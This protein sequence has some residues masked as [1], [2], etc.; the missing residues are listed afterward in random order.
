MIPCAQSFHCLF[1]FGYEDRGAKTTGVLVVPPIDPGMGLYM[2]CNAAQLSDQ[3]TLYTHGNDQFT[4]AIT[5]LATAAKAE[6]KVD[7]RPI[8]RF[9]DNGSSLTIEFVDGSSKEETF[10]VHNPKT[11]V[12]GAFVEQL[13]LELSP[14]GDIKAS[15]PFYQTSVRGVFS[16]GDAVNPY[17]AANAAISSGCN[18][19]VAA[20]AQLQA[21]KYGI[22]AML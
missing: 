14:T 9:V 16:A 1:C 3:V 17:K 4:N 15:G 8:K 7:S 22:P 12:N 19:A 18:A 6:F 21:E 5:P 11:S 20:I 10:L 13:G 2:A